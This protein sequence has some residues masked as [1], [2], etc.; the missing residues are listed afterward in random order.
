M[1]KIDDENLKDKYIKK[2]N[3]DNIFSNDM[4]EYMELILFEKNEFICR[5]NEK[6]EYIFFFVKGKAKVYI[7]LQN[8]KSLLLS[9]YY[10]FMVLGDLE[11]V[12]LSRASTNVQVLEDSYCIALPFY[13][14]RNILL[15]DPRY[16]R[17]TCNSLS[18]KLKKSTIN[19][20]INL[21][22]P[23]ENRLASYILAT[24][25][26]TNVGVLKFSGN[27]M[28]I[29]ELLGTSYRH[30]LRTLS[31]LTSKGAIRKRSNY[32]EVIE[33]E[34]LKDLASELYK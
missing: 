22:Y 7:V 29:S 19:G 11:I 31:N 15:E 14:V 3:L 12:S 20:S 4:K 32:Y 27:L 33:I 1:I 17:F 30:L 8:G 28:E 34:I 13:K 2:Y 5:E 10:P 21:L 6:I 23:L 9:F 16:L 24:S 26:R 25:Q 18:K